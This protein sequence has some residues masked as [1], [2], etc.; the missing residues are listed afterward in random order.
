[1][2][3]ISKKKY[4]NNY[5]YNNYFIKHSKD[6]KRI[7]NGV[8]QIIYL[9]KNSNCNLTKIIYN[10]QELNDSKK[11]ADAFGDYFANVGE[12]L[13]REIPKVDKS[14]LDYIHNY[15]PTNSFYLSP[16]TSA[17]IESMITALK[18]GKAT[19]PSSLPINILK[20][21][22]QFISKPL[23]IVFNASFATGI[24][25]S[26]FKIARVIPVFKKGL[27]ININ[28]YRPISLLSVFNKLLGKLMYNR[29]SSFFENLNILYDNQFGFRLN[30]QLS[31]L[32][33]L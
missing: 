20:I 27:Q 26:K 22:K 17:E 2:L 7:W 11:I 31:M 32:F 13:A 21:L 15:S 4:Y 12:N 1:L 8:K 19:G 9:K 5:Y 24:V 16:T 29:L 14:P 28:N 6:S 18:L 33:F 25:P 10:G 23:E 3:R 30:I